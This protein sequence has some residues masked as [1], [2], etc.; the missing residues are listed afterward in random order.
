[1]LSAPD[2]P[3]VSVLLAPQVNHDP[4]LLGPPNHPSRGSDRHSEIGTIKLCCFILCIIMFK[5]VE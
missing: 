3:V 4:Q 1:M 2:F 5:F